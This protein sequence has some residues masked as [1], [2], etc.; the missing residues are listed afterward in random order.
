M[1]QRL[2]V[3]FLT[4]MELGMM[5]SFWIRKTHDNLLLIVILGII[6]TTLEIVS[7][8][9]RDKLTNIFIMSVLVFTTLY[10]LAKGIVPALNAY[11]LMYAIMGVFVIA[12]NTA[13]YKKIK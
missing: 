2:I 3:H 6:A 9:K 12:A 10:W 5:T 11:Y 13:E 8:L 7:L 4:C 1:K